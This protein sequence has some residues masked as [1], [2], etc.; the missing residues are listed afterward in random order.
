[1]T[2]FRDILL[3]RIIQTAYEYE[4]PSI[5]VVSALNHYK[6]KSDQLPFDRA[7]KIIDDVA[8]RNGFEYI[9]N[10]NLQ[11]AINVA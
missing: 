3:E 11:R 5:E 7:C 10:G 4:I 2:K 1:M 9:G 8:L 6:V